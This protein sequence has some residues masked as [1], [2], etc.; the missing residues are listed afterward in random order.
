MRHRAAGGGGALAA[1]AGGARA[2]RAGAPLW[3]DPAAARARA[4]GR[5]VRRARPRRGGDGRRAAG[6]AILVGTRRPLAERAAACGQRH[7]GIAARRPRRRRRVLR[8]LR[9]VPVGARRPLLWRQSHLSLGGARPS[10]V[11][12]YRSRAGCAPNLCTRARRTASASAATSA[13]CARRLAR[14]RHG[15]PA[16]VAHL[17]EPRRRAVDVARLREGRPAVGGRRRPAVRRR[18]QSSWDRDAGSRSVLEPGENKLMLEFVGM[19]REIA[20]L[21]RHT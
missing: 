5:G 10:A 16:A 9:P 6:F 20:M 1:R 8:R 18:G 11:D 3:G 15:A 12:I 2:R 7:G 4:Q 13:S 21:R 17:R 14:P 19:E